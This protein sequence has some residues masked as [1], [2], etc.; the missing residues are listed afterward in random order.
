MF[1]KLE[2]KKMVYSRKSK[3]GVEHEYFRFRSVA[4]FRCDNCDSL[5]ER[6]LKHIQAKRLSNNYFHVCSNCDSKRFGQKRAVEKKKMWDMP[7]GTD[8]PVSKF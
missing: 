5:F 6:D 3:T 8:L 1:L 4:L 7:A 2:R